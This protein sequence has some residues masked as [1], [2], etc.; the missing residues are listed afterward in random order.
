[1]YPDK[2]Y[3]DL[4]SSNRRSI[5]FSDLG[6]ITIFL[7]FF[8]VG[9]QVI[10]EL[11]HLAVLNWYGCISSMD[12]GFTFLNGF[13]ASIQPLCT[14]TDPQLLLFYGSGYLLTLAFG[15]GLNIAGLRRKTDRNSYFL[16]AAGTGALLSI[17]LTLGSYGD[18]E[19]FLNVLGVNGFYSAVVKV[20]LILGVLGASL[21][22]IGMLLEREERRSN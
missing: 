13:Y 1:M 19:L 10:H 3:E 12:T 11:G 17:L 7:T 4:E 2:Y 15:I 9:G 6:I 20:F 5:L 16:S 8:L 18:I 14:L 22:N 21:N